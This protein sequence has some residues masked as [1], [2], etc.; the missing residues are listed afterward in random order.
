MLQTTACDTALCSLAPYHRKLSAIGI[1]LSASATDPPREH[2][3]LTMAGSTFIDCLQ[4]AIIRVAMPPLGLRGQPEPQE[5]SWPAT[6]RRSAPAS[7]LQM[8]VGP[9]RPRHRP[10]GGLPDEGRRSSSPSPATPPEHH[11]AQY[12]L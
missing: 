5:C 12:R 10:D 2:F 3:S 9:P 7:L 11:R 4:S 6:P 1:H 8:S